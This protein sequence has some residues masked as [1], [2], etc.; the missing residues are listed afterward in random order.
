MRKWEKM[1]GSPDNYYYFLLVA[2]Y[3][4]P[5]PTASFFRLVNHLI[6]QHNMYLKFSL[7]LSLNINE[8]KHHQ[9]FLAVPF[10]SRR[11]IDKNH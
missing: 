4:I 9:C 6:Q 1:D 3:L 7:S 8:K 10:C 2:L 11:N 5:F